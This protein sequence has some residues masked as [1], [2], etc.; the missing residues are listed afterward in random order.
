MPSWVEVNELKPLLDAVGPE[1][2]HVLMHFETE[3]DIDRALE[4]AEAYR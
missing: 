4:I 2:V 1:G 3:R